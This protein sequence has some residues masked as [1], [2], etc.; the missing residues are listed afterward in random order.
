[1]AY[2]FLLIDH[3]YSRTTWC[4]QHTVRFK[5]AIA[6]AARMIL[7]D[8]GDSTWAFSSQLFKKITGVLTAKAKK[9]KQNK[10]I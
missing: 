6:L 8:K 4:F 7:P 5:A 9:I 2:S 1:M 10:I 3:V